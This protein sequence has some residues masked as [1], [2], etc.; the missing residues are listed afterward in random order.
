MENELIICQKGTLF[1][2][3]EDKVRKMVKLSIYE[4]GPYKKEILDGRRSRADYVLAHV[5][6]VVCSY[7]AAF[8]LSLVL[9]FIYNFHYLT[10]TA[11]A[12]DYW[13]IFSML[14]ALYLLFIVGCMFFSSLYFMKKY[15]RTQIAL[16]EYIEQL[17]DLHQ[18]YKNDK[19]KTDDTAAD[20]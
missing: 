4:K 1:M 17:D 2:V 5:L 3:N 9:I 7:T 13:Q 15:D 6:F 12:L 16:K 19:E 18:F 10:T 8:I 14:F 20:D 11:G